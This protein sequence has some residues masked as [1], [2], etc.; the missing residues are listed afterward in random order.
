M[1]EETIGSSVY[2]RKPSSGPSPAAARSAALTSSTDVSR[3]ASTVRS[4]TLPVGTGARTAMPL[5]LPFSS[6]ITSPIAFAAP[7]EAGIRLIAAARARR[8]SLCGMSW[9]RWSDV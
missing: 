6:G 8:R 1:S 5:S 3:S 4:T 7:V 9:S 2:S